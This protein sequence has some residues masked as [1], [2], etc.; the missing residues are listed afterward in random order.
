[1]PLAGL[2]P[3][4][5]ALLRDAP[6][7]L[8]IAEIR[9]A[10][11]GN[12]VSTDQALAI[13]ELAEERGI[14]FTS[15]EPAQRN[16]LLVDVNASGASP[17]VHVRARGWQLGRDGGKLLATI[18]PDSLV[19][20]T[21]Q[22]ERWSVS[23]RPVLESLLLGFEQHLEPKLLHRLGVR[24]VNRLVDTEAK[25]PNAWR[26][27][28]SDSFL[29]PILDPVIGDKVAA[30]QQQIELALGDG[31]GALL[32]HGAFVDAAAQNAI[33]YLM[34]IDVFDAT[35]RRFI[36]ADAIEACQRLNRTALSLFKQ[37]MRPESWL[38]AQEEN[39][40]SKPESD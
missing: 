32:R 2:P 27:R 28:I 5:R 38:A 34:D 9:F 39:V 21:S 31:Q 3:A 1:M 13:K 18:M 23:L 36:S 14:K 7:E 24:Y 37:A 26:N 8:A 17:Q 20:Q 40:G 33:S 10:G 6:V 22:Y 12:S 19:V 35:T 30:A 15:M 4:G 25:A 11:V 29:G 16:E